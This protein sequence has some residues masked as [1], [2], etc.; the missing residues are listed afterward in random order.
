MHYKG[1]TH[2]A[3]NQS[4][5]QSMSHLGIAYAKNMQLLQLA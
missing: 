3:N 5:Y 2:N 1:M 4:I